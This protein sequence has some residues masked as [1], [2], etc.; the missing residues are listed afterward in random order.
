ML[1]YSFL[2]EAGERAKNEDSISVCTKDSD[3]LFVLCDGLGGHGSGEVASNAAVQAA[4]KVFLEETLPPQAMITRCIEKAQSDIFAL[5]QEA[6]RFDTCKTTIT[7]LLVTGS[8]AYCAHVGDSRI[9][10]FGKNKLIS[11]TMDHSVP[12]MLVMQGEIKEK[13]IRFHEDRNRLVR[14]LGND[15]SP[16]KIDFSPAIPLSA[17][18]HFLLCSDGFWEWIDEKDMIKQLKSTKDVNTWL[19]NMRQIVVNTGTGNH[20]DNFS[21]IAVS[22]V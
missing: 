14:V 8:T 5:Q 17:N 20:M 15:A 2:S 21:A 12:Q 22:C 1:T 6:L 7:I 19:S 10:L 9:Y 11:R 16:P 4:K 18:M 13:D 3:Y